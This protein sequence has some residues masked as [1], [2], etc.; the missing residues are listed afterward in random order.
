M[1][2]KHDNFGNR[3]YAECENCDTYNIKE[4]KEGMCTEWCTRIVWKYLK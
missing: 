4:V 3:I 1:T 2:L